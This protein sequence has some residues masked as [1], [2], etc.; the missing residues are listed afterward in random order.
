MSMSWFRSVFSF[1]QISN[2]LGGRAGR[3]SAAYF[4]ERTNERMDDT[5]QSWMVVTRI[6]NENMTCD[7]VTVSFYE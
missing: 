4:L 3:D 2:G 5:V 6:M 1:E 7:Y